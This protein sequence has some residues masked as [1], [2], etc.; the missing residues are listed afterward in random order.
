MAPIEHFDVIWLLALVVISYAAIPLLM[1]A[2]TLA[3]N[4]ARNSLSEVFRALLRF[5]RKIF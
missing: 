3:R 1:L 5:W 4:L 2:L